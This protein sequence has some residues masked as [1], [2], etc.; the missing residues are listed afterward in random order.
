MHGWADR[1]P[2]VRDN[3]GRPSVCFSLVYN[4]LMVDV[5]IMDTSRL[6]SYHVI[7]RGAVT[8][9]AFLS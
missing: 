8:V 9:V 7:T 6:A 2:G 3:A 5:L 1:H 4:G